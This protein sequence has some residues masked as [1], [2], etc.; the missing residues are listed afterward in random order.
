MKLEDN[1]FIFIHIPKCAGTT[2]RENILFN[3]KSEQVLCIYKDQNSEF[4]D[5]KSTENYISTLSEKSKYKKY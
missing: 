1:L 4:S 2:L 5:A 3:Y